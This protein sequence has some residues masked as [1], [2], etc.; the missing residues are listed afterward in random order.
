MQI[1]CLC[2][3]ASSDVSMGAFVPAVFQQ[4]CNKGAVWVGHMVLGEHESSEAVHSLQ[5]RVNAERA[6]SG[7]GWAMAA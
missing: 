6:D 4:L 7:H 3:P 2:T 1:A 5:D